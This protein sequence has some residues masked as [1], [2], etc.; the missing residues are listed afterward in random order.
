[1]NNRMD[2]FDR[3]LADFGESIGIPQMAFDEDGLCHIRIDDEY[4]ITFR[5]D[6]ENHNLVLVGLLTESLPENLDHDLVRDMLATGVEPLRD[7][8]AAIG[9]E[10]QSGTVILHRTLPLSRIDRPQLEEILG[11]FILM[12]KDWSGR[13]GGLGGPAEEEQAPPPA[14]SRHHMHHG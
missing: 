4:P 1:M 13:L 11:S 9:L 8:G 3:L 12:Q 7:N 5:R 2:G 14:A 10:P 6:D